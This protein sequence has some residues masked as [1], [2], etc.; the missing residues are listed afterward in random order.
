MPWTVWLTTSPRRLVSVEVLDALVELDAL[1][2]EAPTLWSATYIEA[3]AGMA[4][5]QG[6]VD[7]AAVVADY[8][9]HSPRGSKIELALLDGPRCVVA[10]GQR[11]VSSSSS[12]S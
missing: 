7:I 4:R 9:H 2:G 10:I 12:L 8:A 1:V 6:R 3:I 5:M 11:V